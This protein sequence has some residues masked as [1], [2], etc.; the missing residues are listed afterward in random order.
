MMRAPRDATTRQ[1]H[2]RPYRRFGLGIAVAAVVVIASWTLVVR[3]DVTPAEERLF[4]VVNTAPDVLWPLLW[5]PMQ[6]GTIVAPVV[7]AAAAA[8][9]LR[10]WR[11]PTAA[12]IAGYTAWAAA[13]VVKATVVRY[14]PDALLTD[15]VLREGAHGLGFVSGHAAIATALATALWPYLSTRGRM[16]SLALVA[17]VG[18]GRIY[19]GAHLPLD[20]VGGVAIGALIG[21]AANAVVGL[22]SDRRR[23]N[24]SGTGL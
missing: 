13:Q 6:L 15:V 19:A 17:A 7:V 14:R 23:V 12:L 11:P 22:P 20:V 16:L 2:H 18:L 10:R 1:A 4:R 3:P 21:I 24:S 9:A 8:A 5:P